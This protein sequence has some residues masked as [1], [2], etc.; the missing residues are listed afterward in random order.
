[1]RGRLYQSA[2]L[3]TLISGILAACSS[4]E[5][6]PLDPAQ[7]MAT[8][9]FTRGDGG[10]ACYRIP[11]LLATQ[12]G[13]LLAFVEGRRN[14]QRDYGDIDVLMRRSV[15]G[16]RTWSEPRRV[17]DMG[18]DTCG[19]PTAV[20]DRDT[21]TIWLAVCWNL[22]EDWEYDVVLGES[23]DTRRVF[24][25]CSDDDGLTWS[26]PREITD[27]V[28]T[29]EMRWYGAGP[30]TGIQLERGLHRGRLIIPCD[31]SY[32]DPE[33]QHAGGPY[34]LGAHAIY[35]DD[36]GASWQ[37]GGLIRPRVA[38]PQIVELAAGGG[39]LANLRS[40]LGR[41]C[42]AQA[43]SRNGGSTWTTPASVPTLVEPTCQ[44]SILRYSWPASATGDLLIFT[45]PAARSRR[46][47]A[48]RIS[49]DGGR[50]WSMARLLHE[51]PAA[52]SCLARL[53]DGY[54]GCLFEAGDRELYE[55]IDLAVFPVSALLESLEQ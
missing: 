54:V 8:T 28:K 53:R 34:S 6:Q 22:A 31:H 39:I 19:N 33:G 30:G 20:E 52:Y 23:R 38:E 36:H 2:C 35:S 37:L 46:N 29:P 26:P 42:R 43:V 9:L 18:S 11:S 10:Y 44:A 47:L 21:G 12:S 41:P 55:R 48:V 49:R 50:T 32:P 45:N 17:A 5:I 14:S 7:L 3:V 24:I 27:R 16:G 1:M 25:L 40:Y 4:H 51:G 13:T 15:D